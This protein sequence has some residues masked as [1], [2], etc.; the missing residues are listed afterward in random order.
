MWPL[1]AS[2]T[3]TELKDLIFDSKKLLDSD[4]R[5]KVTYSVMIWLNTEFST[6]HPKMHAIESL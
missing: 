6:L 2:A 4:V 3:A 5:A 1:Y